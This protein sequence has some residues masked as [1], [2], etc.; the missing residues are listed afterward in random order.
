MANSLPLLLLCLL[1]EIKYYEPYVPDKCFIYYYVTM[2]SL[3]GLDIA[4]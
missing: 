4:I 1:E 3:Y 2:E